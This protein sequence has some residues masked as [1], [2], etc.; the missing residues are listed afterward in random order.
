MKSDRLQQIEKLYHAANDL[1]PSERSRFLET[2]CAGDPDLRREVAELL[3]Q[4][5]G[6][7]RLEQPLGQIAAEILTTEPASRW[8]PGTEVGPYRILGLVGS[9]GMGDVFRARDTRLGR[10][11]AI[12][13]ARESF[14][15]RFLRE[16]RAISALNHPNVCTLYD[17]GPD[18]LVMEYVEGRKLAGPLS[19]ERVVEYAL[20]ILDALAAAH[21]KGIVHRDLKPANIMVTRQGIKLLDFGLARQ[22][23][24]HELPSVTLG[25]LTAAGQIAGTIQYMS[26]E[27][28]QGKKADARSDIFSFGCLLYEMISGERAFAGSTPASVIAA[29]LEREPAPLNILPGLERTVRACLLKDPEQRFQTVVD[30]KRELVWAMDAATPARKGRSRLPWILAGVAAASAMV[31]AFLYW[32]RPLSISS[33]ANVEIATS[34]TLAPSSFALSPD[35]RSIAY[36]ASSAGRSVLW[37]RPFDAQSGSPLPDTEGALNPFWSPDGRSLGFFANQ[38]LKSIEVGASHSE[39][40]ADADSTMAQGTW[41]AAGDILFTS[42]GRIL[43]RT[44]AGGRSVKVLEFGSGVSNLRSPV[45][46]PD[47]RSFLFLAMTDRPT[48]WLGS[49]GSAKS[50][51]VAVLE[52][53]ADSAGL[54]LD[55]GWLLRV[56]QN[57]LEARRFDPATGELSGNPVVLAHGVGVDPATLTGSFSVSGTG[58]LAWRQT[59]GSQ[60]QLLWLDHS[61]HRVGTFGDPADDRQSFPELS[62]DGQR[63]AVARGPLGLRDIWLLEGIHRKR[64]TRSVADERYSIWSPDGAQVVFGSNRLGKFD[65]YRKAADGSGDEELIL[66]SPEDKAPNSWSPDGRYILYAS[67]QNNGDLMV[68]PTTGDRKPIPFLTTPLNERQGMFSPDGKMVAYQ[69]NESGRFE[70]YL[71]PFQGPGATLQISAGGGIMP[72][73]NPN[74]RELFYL[75]KDGNMMAVTLSGSPGHLVASAPAALFP[76]QIAATENKQ[77]YDVGKGG[78]FLINSELE[79]ADD[80]IRLMLNALL[81]LR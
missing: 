66:G 46:L 24:N 44:A 10:D 72:R 53:P 12:K 81:R 8:K 41:N 57:L 49:I 48:I 21:A 50:K 40:L 5:E 70:I 60:R 1:L 31:L 15:A 35:G 75:S 51:R 36:V 27:Q 54:Y 76:V 7:G 63:V 65:L 19:L 25:T 30:L 38:K 69:S 52:S 16:A 64:F 58:T 59:A 28:L 33:V 29:V 18:Y 56:R 68:L 6:E 9:G 20:Q 39:S 23:A 55:S 26:P 45:F 3:A 17:V 11:V 42:G 32:A 47:G 34:P 67:Q 61:G 43:R 13:T 4:D 71:R 79:I 73:W 62:P 37:V 14:G 77:G 78:R 74:G 2:A 80:P 22:T